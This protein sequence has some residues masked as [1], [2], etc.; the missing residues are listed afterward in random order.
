MTSTVQ[1][2]RTTP[3]NFDWIP[4]GFS[5]R[6]VETNGTRL[7]AVVG[8]SGPSVVLLHGWPETS[9][10][11]RRV[12]PELAQRYT[13]VV[14]DLR[15]AGASDRPTEGYGKVDQAEDLRGLLRGLDIAGPSVVMGHDI[16]AMVALA[17]ALAHP[18]DVAALVVLDVIF[19]GLGMEEALNVAESGMWHFGFFMAPHVPE[20]LFD[21]HE[22]EF[23]ETSFRA[24]SNPGTFSD[25]DLDYYVQAYRGRDRLRGGFEQYRTFLEDGKQ[26]RELLL[27]KPLTMPVLAVGGGDRMGGS[28]AEALRPHAPRLTAA[29]APTGH[30][31]PEEDPEWLLTNVHEFLDAAARTDQP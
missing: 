6:F 10:A 21:G 26:T 15:G 17:W 1:D 12:M 23:F 18:E 28:V 24:I 8:G 31:V 16:G 3:A 20:M 29:V 27:R 7:A 4:E 9:R 14:P 22:A 2:T 13:V 19:P 25:E 5:V 30:F 11:W